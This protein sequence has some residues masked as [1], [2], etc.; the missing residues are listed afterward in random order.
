M[1]DLNKQYVASGPMSRSG[2]H[3]RN[4]RRRV[5]GRGREE[6][7]FTLILRTNTGCFLGRLGALLGGNQR[8]F[9][10]AVGVYRTPGQDRLLP[11]LL[12]SITSWRFRRHDTDDE[13]AAFA[14]TC[15][16]AREVDLTGCK[17]ITDAG[18]KELAKC[19]MLHTINL[20]GCHITD[21]CLKELEARE[22]QIFL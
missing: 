4:R 11:L 19:T 6:T 9:I 14:R 13:I 5:R 2:A 8:A 21:A 12:R 18:L 1:G 3:R 15:L 22:L 17:K 7:T 10:L 16:Q 20:E